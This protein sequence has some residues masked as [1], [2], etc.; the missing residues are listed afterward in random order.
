MKNRNSKNSK[1]GFSKENIRKNNN[2]RVDNNKPQKIYDD[3]IYEK[4]KSLKTIQI[5]HH[6]SNTST[7]NFLLE[8]VNNCSAI[9]SSKRKKF[10]HPSVETIDILKKYNFDILI[11]E[12]KGAIK[13]K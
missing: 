6:G 10:G 5:G 13:T 1:K 2:V 7:S 3:I 8:N 4:L 12:K 9:I 11:T